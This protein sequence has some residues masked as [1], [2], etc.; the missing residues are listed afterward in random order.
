MSIASLFFHPDTLTLPLQIEAWKGH[1]RFFE[2]E[3]ASACLLLL[4]AMVLWRA[5]NASG[6]QNRWIEKKI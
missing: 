4:S 6:T 3:V 1:Y 2:A 5:L